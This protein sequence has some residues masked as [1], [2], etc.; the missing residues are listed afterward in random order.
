MNQPNQ[1]NITK[2]IPVSLIPN[3]ND[4]SVKLLGIYLEDKLNFKDHFRFMHK[5]ISQAVFSLRVMKHILDK[6]HLLLLYNSYLK[7]NLEYASSLF[8]TVSKTTIKPLFVL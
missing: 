8:T 7:S 1:C 5:K 2:I 4:S 3:L 6:R